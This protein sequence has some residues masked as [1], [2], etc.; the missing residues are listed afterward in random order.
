MNSEVDTSILNSVNIKRFTNT[1]IEEY[2]GEIDRSNSA[3]WTVTFPDELGQQLERRQGTLVFDPADRELGAGDLLVQPGTR[4]F[5]ALLDLVQQPGSIGRLRLTEDTLQ[6]NPPNI[7]RE[8]GLSVA[9]TD[10]R[11][12][13]SDFALS[14]HF[15]VR[16]ETPSSFHNEEM[17][18]VT[19]DPETQT[20]LPDLTAR[21]T[22]HLPQLLQQNNEQ[23]PR[24][25]SQT[26]VQHS[27][28]EAQQAVIDR[29]RPVVSEIQTEADESANERIGEVSDWYSQRREELDQQVHDQQQEIRK[30]RQKRRNARKNS[31]RQKYTKNER[32][33]KKELEQLQIKIERKKQELDKKESAEIDSVIERNEID[34]D[35][36][37]LG[38]TDV[39]YVRGVLSMELDSGHAKE[40][41]E[42][43][44]LPATDEFRGLDCHV[45]SQDLTD[46]V[47]PQLCANG[48]LIGDPCS[49]NCRSCGLAYC[50]GCKTTTHFA[51]CEICWE[52]VCHSCVATCT[53]CGTASC[54]DH[55][56]RCKTC[57]T[58]TCHFC[59]EECATCGE[60]HCDAHLSLCPDCGEY[61]CEAHL[62]T[63]DSCGSVR[64]GTHIG[65]CQ[66]CGDLVCSDHRDA[67]T[68]CEGIFCY[69][70]I[71]ACEHCLAEPDQEQR[72]FCHE[73]TTECTVGG[74][75][76][77]SAHRVTRTLGSGYVC[78][79]HRSMCPSCKVEYSEDALT[80]GRCSACT[81]IGDAEDKH[82]PEEIAKEFRSVT[83]GGNNAYMVILGKKLLGRNKLVVYDIQAK[84]ESHRHNAGMVKQLIGEYQ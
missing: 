31:T 18:S 16:F 22:S 53:S 60:F 66:S 72:Q 78:E 3:K 41:V 20:R 37:L 38:I 26:K 25:I 27:F 7:L 43:S 79:D 23:S 34:V 81:S 52:D 13:T 24:E 44:Y 67:C 57:N 30:W 65:D 1:V 64:C 83:A 63:C 75:V 69:H 28:R 39:T 77:C 12:N 14:F 48:H 59:G 51:A 29:S 50:T 46:G 15:C 71:E 70:H 82:I 35:I 11:K 19:V 32:Q 33:A 76:V 61:H 2:G 45:C 40:I 47:R 10:F 68:T 80:G 54:A 6:V 42:V 5:S 36:S 8:S 84:E 49:T 74:E 62:Q 9:V 73:H 21:L 58:I 4:V 17:F 56:S 55:N